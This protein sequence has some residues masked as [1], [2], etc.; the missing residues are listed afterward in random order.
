NTNATY[1]TT[2]RPSDLFDAQHLA[3]ADLPGGD[4]HQ[5]VVVDE[6]QRLLQREADRRDQALVVVLA[7]GAEVGELLAAQGVDREV[8]VLGVRSEEHTSELQSRENL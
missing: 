4:F 2:Q 5:L 8:V 1:F 6:L 3:Q 7:G